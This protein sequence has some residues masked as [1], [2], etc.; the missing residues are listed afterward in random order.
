M[1]NILSILLI[2]IILF[3]C[4]KDPLKKSVIEPL[5]IDEIKK[6]LKFQ[7]ENNYYG[8]EF[9]YEKVQE[10]QE[11]TKNDNL[12]KVKFETLLYQHYFDS[13]DYLH[14]F[15]LSEVISQDSILSILNQWEMIPEYRNTYDTLTSIIEER[16]R[17]KR[18]GGTF[19]RESYIEI[20][21]RYLMRKYILGKFWSKNLYFF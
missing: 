3:G 16:E 17:L 10:F 2:S 11:L 15:D 21:T 1:K 18:W 8:F 7:D 20:N 19:S 13:K 5:E 9:F 6:I 4:S 14:S 12:T